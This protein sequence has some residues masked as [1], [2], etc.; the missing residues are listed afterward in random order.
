MQP[1]FLMRRYLF[2]L[3]KLSAVPGPRRASCSGS[4]NSIVVIGHKASS[5]QPALDKALNGRQS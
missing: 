5:A 2:V 4:G 3:A 1:R